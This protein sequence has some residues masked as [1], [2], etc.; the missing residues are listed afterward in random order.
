MNFTILL[1]LGLFVVSRLYKSSSSLSEVETSL[2]GHSKDVPVK[3]AQVNK[4]IVLPYLLEDQFEFLE[5][6]DSFFRQKHNVLRT[7]V[8]WHNFTQIDWENTRKGPGE[9][10]KAFKLTKTEDINL[11]NELNKVNGYWARASDL[12]SKNYIHFVI[13]Y[14]KKIKKSFDVNFLYFQALIDQ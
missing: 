8:D 1:L 13:K 4:P 6:S 2:D 7:K 12:I 9:G 5:P 10:G 11:N 14:T 3:S